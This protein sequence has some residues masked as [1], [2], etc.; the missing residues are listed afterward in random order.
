MKSTLGGLSVEGKECV[1]YLKTERAEGTR[2][3]RE[4]GTGRGG[5]KGQVRV[6]GGVKSRPILLYRFAFDDFW[7]RFTPCFA[8]FWLN[9]LVGLLCLPLASRSTR[10]PNFQP[11]PAPL[12]SLRRILR[13]L[14]EPQSHKPQFCPARSCRCHRPCASCASCIWGCAS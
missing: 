10:L 1:G 7:M 2:G 3:D 8:L 9:P 12:T 5:R 14:V 11:Q 13:I 4:R 6:E